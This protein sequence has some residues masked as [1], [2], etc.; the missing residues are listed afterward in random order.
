MILQGRLSVLSAFS[1]QKI[2]ENTAFLLKFAVLLSRRW[3]AELY[4][5]RHVWIVDTPA[6]D[7]K[8]DVLIEKPGFLSRKSGL[9]H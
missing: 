4:H 2:G 1:A 5:V 3:K 8:L 9:F 7:Y 6:F